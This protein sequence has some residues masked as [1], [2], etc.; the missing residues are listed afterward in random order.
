MQTPI[1]LALVPVDLI[2][3][4]EHPSRLAIQ[5][6]QLYELESSIARLGLLQP[7]G[8]HAL[9]ASD[10]YA[11]AYGHRRLLCVR[12]LGWFEVPALILP[13]GLSEADA[14]QHE[15][16]QRVQLTPL[17]E[18]YELQALRDQGRSIPDLAHRANRS[19]SWVTQRLR[20]LAYPPDILDAVHLRHLPLAV[21]DQLAQVTHPSYRAQLTTEALDHGASARTAAAWVAHY[22]TDQARIEANTDTIE[23]IVARRDAFRVTAACDYCDEHSDLASTRT[24]RLCARCSAGLIGAKSPNPQEEARH[25]HP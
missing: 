2:N 8:V 13:A 15:N 4:P 5:P 7:I 23:Q 24:W 21:A 20:L 9:P 1:R 12:R 11:L 22:L 10:R 16:S 19:E 3:E 18:A 25:A 17:E 6:E 14:R